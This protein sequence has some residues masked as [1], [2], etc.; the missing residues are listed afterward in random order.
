MLF[1]SYQFPI[2]FA[3]ICLLY[4]VAPYGIR[5]LVLLVGSYY[6]Y[7]CWNPAY[8]LLIIA[9]TIVDYVAARRI[10]ACNSTLV[11][12]SWLAVS[13]V[14][15]LGLLFTFKYF[16]FFVANVTAV[17]DA[18]G[19]RDDLPASDLLLPV[20]IS[21]YTFQTLSYT[22]DVYRRRI[23]PER[24]LGIFAL[25]VSFFPQLVAGPIERAGH[26]L[27]QFRV[28]HAIDF[29]RIANGLG[30]IL[31]GLFKKVVIADRLAEYVNC[32]YADPHVH[33]P[34][35]LLLATFFFAFQ[36]YCDFSG[37]SDIAIGAARVLGF[38]LLQNFR[39]P[40][41]ASS[42]PDFW[43]RWHIS[44]SSWFRD[45][46]Y[47]PLGGNCPT[48]RWIWSRNILAVFVLSGLWHGANWTFVVWGGLHAVYYLAAVISA[49]AIR[50]MY[51]TLGLPEFARRGI[52]IAATFCLV[53]VSWC[54]FRAANLSDAWYIVS[55]LAYQPWGQLYW[56][57]SQ[58]ATQ[59]GLALIGLLVLIQI[60]Q[61]ELFRGRDAR[62]PSPLPWLR[63][64][65]SVA[66]L[67][68]MALLGKTNHDFIYF[69]F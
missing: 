27:P 10:A 47:V 62:L 69:Q 15:N 6:F 50:T 20:G 48:S 30:L 14:V 56:G 49:P 59:L 24:Q 52:G 2:F 65:S 33:S 31:W 29:D 12:R 34:S 8:L 44:L 4:F 26:L 32:I 66:L 67:V 25:Y 60:S 9:S 11:R 51:E 42:I 61:S 46:V 38:D 18:C 68:G 54:V 1:N 28:R 40:Y 58:L 45:Y 22:I 37:Y 53:L 23:R 7:M 39:L 21:F 13:L 41:F 19:W 17:L 3:V 36:I 16:N 35:T 57:P 5:W 64:A 55:A 63:W 43:R